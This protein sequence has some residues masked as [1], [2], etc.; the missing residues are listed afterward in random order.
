MNTFDRIYCF[1]NE[2]GLSRKI[3]GIRKKQL[4]FW[5][6]VMLKEGIENFTVN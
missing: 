3:T 5:W 6:H 1:S 2:V 4:N